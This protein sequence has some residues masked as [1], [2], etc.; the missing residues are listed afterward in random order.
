L[1]FH[2]RLCCVVKMKGQ[3]ALD[4]DFIGSARSMHTNGSLYIVATPIG[5]LADCSEHAREILAGVALIL[6]EDTRHS[7]KLLNHYRIGTPMMSLHEHNEHRRLEELVDRL[8]QGED[9]ALISD[10]GTPLISDPGYRLVA[11]AHAAGVPVMSVPGPSALTAAL[12]VAGLPTDRFVFEGYLPGRQAARRRRLAELVDE[13]RTLVF[14]EAPHRLEAMLADA[15]AMFS[16]DRAASLCKELSKQHERTVSATL[17]EL[18]AWLS[19]DPRHAQGEFVIVV[20]GNTDAPAAD[21]PR[22]L[23]RSLLRHDVSVKTAAAIVSEVS[24]HS[25]NELYQLALEIVNSE[26]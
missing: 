20:A 15:A 2:L 25:R 26:R 17:G 19:A 14:Y 9:L 4:K 13:P 24:D 3:Q 22:P 12:S 11:A 10:A 6:A 16:A 7:R 1:T 21:D 23:L 8:Q 5:N 18:R